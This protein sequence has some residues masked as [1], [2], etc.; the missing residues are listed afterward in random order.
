MV[1]WGLYTALSND[2]FHETPSD[3]EADNCAE[4]ATYGTSYEGT[5]GGQGDSAEAAK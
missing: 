3:D 4:A 1:T 2:D 5:E